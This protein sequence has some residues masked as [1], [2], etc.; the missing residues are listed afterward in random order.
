MSYL[1]AQDTIS[2]KEGKAVATIDGNVEDM[3]YIKKIEA[4]VEKTKSEI[5]T[6][7]RR[8]TQHKATGWSGTGSMTI[9]YITTNFRKLMTS[10]MQNGIDTYFDIL[11]TNEDPALSLIH[12]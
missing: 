7:G 5:K 12:I 3:F 8:G 11:V 6:L 4:N 1:K 2:G 9:Y 10:Y